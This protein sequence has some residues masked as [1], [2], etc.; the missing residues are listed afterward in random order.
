[1]FEPLFS[2]ILSPNKKKY[3]KIIK[4]ITLI[5]FIKFWPMYGQ[6]LLIKT[7]TCLLNTSLEKNYRQNIGLQHLK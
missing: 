5:M 4:N 7:K 1:M 3:S 2:S 6:L